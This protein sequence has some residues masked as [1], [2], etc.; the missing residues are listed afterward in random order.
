M[1]KVK[2]WFDRE[3]YVE[4]YPDVVAAGVDPWSHFVCYGRYEG[5]LPGRNRAIAWEHHLWRG[6]EAMMLP[7]LNALL[8]DDDAAPWERNHAAW[9]LGRWYAWQGD[10]SRVNE[11]MRRFVVDEMA[12]A[13]QVGPQLLQLEALL[14]CGQI[15]EAAARIEGFLEQAPD[16]PDLLLAQANLLAAHPLRQQSESRTADVERLQLINRIYERA[17]LASV[18]FADAPLGPLFDRLHVAAPGWSTGGDPAPPLVS[19]IV[20]AFNAAPTLATVLRALHQ[21]SWPRLE[22]LVVNDASTDATQQVLKDF[23]RQ[24]PAR[25]GFVI[26]LLRHPENRGAY[27]ARNTGLAVAKGEFITTHDSDDWSHP[28]K[29][30]HQ[31]RALRDDP[32]LLASLSHWVRCTPDL[33]F[34]RWRIEEGWIYRNVSSLM[35]RRSVFETLGYWDAVEVN[36]DTEYYHR[37]QAAFGAGAMR[38]VLPGV[39]LAFGR[40]RRESLSHQDQTSLRTRYIGLRRD[41]EEAAQR[42]HQG[43]RRPQDLHLEAEPTR[44][45]FLAPEAMVRGQAPVRSV[46]P[47]DVVQQSGLFDAGWYVSAYADLHDQ[48][49]EA[50]EHYWFN[51]SGEGRDPG[52]NFSTSGYRARYAHQPDYA[53]PALLHYLTKGR[54]AGNDPIPVFDGAVSGEAASCTLLVCAHQV[55]AE[56]AGGERSLL[57][58][59]SALGTLG[60]RAVVTLPSAV[61]SGYLAAVRERSAAVVVLPYRWW[62]ARRPACDAT[63]GQFERLIQRFGVEAVYANTLVLEEPLAAA[64]T[65]GI[66]ALIHVR[67]IPTQDAALCEIFDAAPEEIIRRTQEHATLIL[68]NSNRV[69]A[70]F[71]DFPT[72]VVPNVIDPAAYDIPLPGRVHSRPKPAEEPSETIHS[73][74]PEPVG[75]RP[76]EPICSVALISSNL[77]KKGLDDL[78]EVAARLAD[79]PTIR[80]LLIGPG[81]EH[82]ARLRAAQDAGA[83]PSNLVIAGY[84][85]TPQEALVQADVVLNLSHFQESF[86]RTVLEAMAAARPVVCYAWGAL[87]EL[88]VDGE[89][90]YLVPFRD[91]AAVAERVVRLAGDPELRDRMGKAA[92]DRA[93]C[94]YGLET[95]V[96]GLADA[97]RSVGLSVPSF[98]PSG[99]SPW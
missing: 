84:C 50:F 91:V 8:L 73:A 42:W 37:I 58:V 52:P 43:A 11:V 51:G 48:P 49:V 95:M 2:K 24:T 25:P 18:A 68:A 67:E 22:I 77:P 55:M 89:T 10:W 4:M 59:L 38:E 60:V 83:L 76:S 64:R 71:G 61:H 29:I 81:N 78:V 9:A 32:E 45:P 27:A 30:E 82:A 3:W 6:A 94:H 74:H 26:R 12:V 13:T 57:D 41:Y 70:E 40:S 1:D 16:H 92:R 19:V 90:G 34:H 63:Q 20:P 54:A 31:A 62:H 7:R 93:A 66:P 75:E 21:Q 47:M 15:A 79:H 98:P 35:F 17:G 5:R 33:H 56:L 87:P 80:F 85:E 88:V 14:Q 65:L 46:H 44:R 69:A 72:V 86:G 99:D 28:Q 23:V 53:E 96:N 36:A 97:L 39:P